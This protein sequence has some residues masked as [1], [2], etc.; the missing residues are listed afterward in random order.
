[1]TTHPGL[2]IPRDALETFY[3]DVPDRAVAEEAASLVV[4]N[5][6]SVVE[7]RIDWVPWAGGE[8]EGEVGCTYVLC[9]EDRAVPVEVARW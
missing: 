7:G 9:E 6:R 4:P 5:S 1:M 3:H 2:Q 8:G